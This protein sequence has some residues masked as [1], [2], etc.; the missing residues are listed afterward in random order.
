MA[1]KKDRGRFSIKF[2]EKDPTHN[3]VIK[4]LEEQGPHSKAP[5]IANA[6]LHYIHCSQTP[7]IASGQAADKA[8]IKEIVLEILSHKVLSS[9]LADKDISAAESL[10]VN[11]QPEEHQEHQ[12]S[13]PVK[14]PLDD[15]TLAMI[16]DTLSAFRKTGA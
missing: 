2:N 8:Y 3:I 10:P 15:R 6:I 13:D 7:D 4:I 11:K 1:A 9:S 16:S 14:P 12:N 5:F